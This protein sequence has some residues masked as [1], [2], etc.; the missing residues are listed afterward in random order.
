MRK[1][2]NEG[3][4]RYLKLV[5]NNAVFTYSP[6]LAKRRDVIEITEAEA[7]HLIDPDKYPAPK[8]LTNLKNIAPELMDIMSKLKPGQFSELQKAAEQLVNSQ[9]AIDLDE[10]TEPPPE[11]AE[12]LTED[13]EEDVDDSDEEKPYDKMNMIGKIDHIFLKHGK[14]L[15]P[16]EYKKHAD[17]DAELEKLEAEEKAA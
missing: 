10:A 15:N 9:S 14:V 13:P 6:I 1:R 8:D 2:K 17:I 3:P 5:T 7:F 11:D 16:D 12:P 4:A